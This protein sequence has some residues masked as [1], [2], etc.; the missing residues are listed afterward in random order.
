VDDNSPPESA[1]AAHTL[2]ASLQSG[3]FIGLATL[4]SGPLFDQAGA[5]GYLAMSG[6]AA[7]GLLGALLLMRRA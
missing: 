2:S 1:S 6:M 4:A 3:L 7:I 5:G